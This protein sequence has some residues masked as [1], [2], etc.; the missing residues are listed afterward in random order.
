MQEYCHTREFKVTYSDCD[1]QDELKPSA[2]LSFGQEIA[3]TSADE[4]GFGYEDL[5]PEG[6]G[7]LVVAVCCELFKPAHPAETLTLSTWPNPPRH[8]FFERQSVAYNERGEKVASLAARWCLLNLKSQKLLT[9]ESLKAHASCPYRNERALDADFSVPKLGGEGEAVYSLTA[10]LS[11]CDHFNHVNNTK[12]ADFFTDCFTH[13]E[14]ETRR[15][16]AFRISYSKQVKAEEE[17]TFYRKDLSDGIALEARVDGN[18][19]T[20]FFAEFSAR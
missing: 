3:G 7:F 12:Y 16:K 10:R 6:K 19:T 1:F 2:I 13:D 5:I 4:L 15:L 14:L 11:H 9:A 20:R 18:A 17:M 8:V